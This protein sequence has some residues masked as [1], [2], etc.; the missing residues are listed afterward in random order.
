M[1]PESAPDPRPLGVYGFMR[2]GTRKSKLVASGA[3]RDVILQELGDNLF[4]HADGR[5]A[6]IMMTK[7]NHYLARISPR[8]RYRA[9]KWSE[10]TDAFAAL[11]E[12]EVLL[13]S[14]CDKGPGI[15]K[16]LRCSYKMEHSEITSEDSISPSDIIEYAFQYHS[17][18]RSLEDR[19]GDM[20]S[21]LSS[22]AQRHPPPTGL[23][24][25]RELTRD[26]RGILL[27]RTESEALLYDFYSEQHSTKPIAIPTPLRRQTLTAFGGTQYY[28]AFPVTPFEQ[29][30]LV[31][32][33]QNFRTRQEEELP[34]SS[35]AFLEDYMLPNSVGELDQEACS[36]QKFL[37]AFDRMVSSQLTK[38]YTV[39]DFDL[40]FDATIRVIH[41]ILYELISRQT[42][43]SAIVFINVPETVFSFIEDSVNEL[44]T[45]PERERSTTWA[46]A[47]D[48]IP[49]LLCLHPE[50]KTLSYFPKTLFK[51]FFARHFQYT[52]QTNRI[53]TSNQIHL[54]RKEA[55]RLRIERF[56][57]DPTEK[58]FHE[59]ARVLLLSGAYSLG[60]FEVDR[61]LDN[62]TCCR[63]ASQWLALQLLE[64]APDAIVSIGR[65]SGSLVREMIP[66]V[67]SNLS[68]VTH[69]NI[70]TGSH[71]RISMA[72][73]YKIPQGARVLV[74]GDVIGTKRTM[75]SVVRNLSHCTVARI[76]TLVDATSDETA[77]LDASD[78]HLVIEAAIKR[79]LVFYFELPPGWTYEDVQLVDPDTHRL[80]TSPVTS[81]GPLWKEIRWSSPTN[82]EEPPEN[83]FLS[84][85]IAPRA[86]VQRGHFVSGDKHLT[87][88]FDT[89]IIVQ[90]H[91][92]QIVDKILRHKEHVKHSSL[93]SKTESRCF[94]L[95][96]DYN[97][98]LEMLAVALASRIS[99]CRTLA[100]SKHELETALDQSTTAYTDGLVLLLDDATVTGETLFRLID[101]AERGNAAQII[102]YVL[103][104][105]GSDYAARRLEQI[106]IYGQAGVHIRYL[107]DVELTTY[108]RSTCPICY[109]I[110]QFRDAMT[111]MPQ[112]TVLGEYFRDRLNAMA[113]QTMTVPLPPSMV[114]TRSH[115]EVTA[116]NE[117]LRLRW[118][119]SCSVSKPAVRHYLTEVL[120]AWESKP[121]RCLL[122]LEVLAFER[123]L[124]NDIGEPSGSL[125]YKKFRHELEQ[126]TN[127][128]L[129]RLESL[130]LQQFESVLILGE[131]IETFY[132]V[133]RIHSL[134]NQ[135][136]SNLEKAK[137]LFARLAV[138]DGCKECPDP[139]LTALMKY[140]NNDAGEG[141]N[142]R[143]LD[144]QVRFWERVC[145]NTRSI[146]SDQLDA[147]RQLRGGVFHEI[148]HLIKDVSEILKDSTFLI[149][150]LKTSWDI[151]RRE[152]VAL[153][154]IIRRCISRQSSTE[155]S[156][157]LHR[158]IAHVGN[159]VRSIDTKLA[160][161][162]DNSADFEPL[163]NT[164]E[165]N[166]KILQDDL[167]GRKGA[168]VLLTEFEVNVKTIVHLAYSRYEKD[169]DK[170]GII[171]NWKVPDDA[172]LVYGEQGNLILVCHNLITNILRWSC[173][174]NLEIGITFGGERHC[175]RLYFADDG[176]GFDSSY[177]DGLTRVQ[178]IA[179]RL[180]GDFQIVSG[181]NLPYW[182]AKNY[183]TVAFIELPSLTLPG[184]K[185]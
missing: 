141:I 171:V 177:G 147:Y 116:D 110:Q 4:R 165:A 172:C 59:N 124:P 111:Q 42:V 37:S 162:N 21:T 170:S 97:P 112:D 131:A 144:E 174:A 66:N 20:L 168:K 184:A 22:E 143:L 41:Y 73:L 109:E 9:N 51:S 173:A 62:V 136:G 69:V 163:R 18:R 169:F 150:E 10:L 63:H 106:R 12:Q 57:L 159:S 108:N 145:E 98:G 132:I 164:F 40:A 27:V 118:L 117:R 115:Q 82:I 178:S 122:L 81:K 6:H 123:I 140:R 70:R 65:R 161:I 157:G 3:L 72:H 152:V 7:V 31:L 151:L 61:A 11:S 8:K 182:I 60:Y 19:L 47:R 154:P 29:T 48:G 137:A 104:K 101:V 92:D 5:A 13:I 71:G 53:V 119:I 156:E 83:L 43:A 175:I 15:A 85:V 94:L 78:K 130:T 176:V 100:I 36:I 158:C 139:V 26:N 75:Q 33:E 133:D 113:D 153:L 88:L 50:R 74:T 87:Y 23:Y 25:L 135:T 105:R 1:A 183:K 84:D 149:D 93:N 142:G 107:T 146:A 128:F 89:P 77:I 68:Q 148:G 114:D 179:Q 120:R 129:Q 16:T 181:Y 134:L 166:L 44:L 125:F 30:T 103:I 34:E 86:A 35:Y 67:P 185:L 167:I 180:Y 127:Y 14:I 160:N 96:P 102:G 138:S 32:H 64:V 58:F 45:T 52:E 49:Y 2:R 38:L 155:Q 99:G 91:L 17:S 76:V 56:M 24:Q 54:F 121:E 39:V 28:L 126:S 95:Y 46:I 80:V 55:M 90:T 79:P